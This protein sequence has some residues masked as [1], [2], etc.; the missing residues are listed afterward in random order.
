MGGIRLEN[1]VYA[2]ILI[3]ADGSEPSDKAVSHGV[4]LAKILGTPEVTIVTAT[5]LLSAVTMSAGLEVGMVIP[6]DD[7]EKTAADSA[8]KTLAAAKQVAESEGVNCTT[9]HIPDQRP[10]DAIIATARKHKCD[11]IVMGSHGRRGIDRLLLGSQ[12]NE[13]LINSTVPVLVVK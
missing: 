11:L 9:E 8:N 3:A 4:K 12:A 5:E 7:Y 1:K 10:S 6:I 2:H 13:V